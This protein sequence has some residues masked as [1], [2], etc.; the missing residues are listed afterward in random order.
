MEAHATF[1]EIVRPSSPTV[2]NESASP[3]NAKKL[4]APPVPAGE[5]RDSPEKAHVDGVDPAGARTSCCTYS[6]APTPGGAS[7]AG[8]TTVIECIVN[9]GRCMS[10][11][12]SC[13]TEQP[14]AGSRLDDLN[15]PRR[16]SS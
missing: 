6:V 15:A 10:T 5:A 4:P 13:D 9:P 3:C 7:P 1:A 11:R 14:V 2:E 16:M 12:S 8:T